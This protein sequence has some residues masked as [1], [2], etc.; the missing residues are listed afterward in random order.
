M[1][2]C[3]LRSLLTQNFLHFLELDR[4]KLREN[5]E[6]LERYSLKDFLINKL[7]QKHIKN[8]SKNE[9]LKP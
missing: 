9:F 5:Q 6:I 8:K 4:L 1:I 2:K 3:K 7:I